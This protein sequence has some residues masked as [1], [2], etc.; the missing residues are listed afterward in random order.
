MSTTSSRVNCPSL[1]RSRIWNPSRISLTCAGGSLARAS[2]LRP[3]VA[4]I[5]AP[6]A[7]CV[8]RVGDAG[9]SRWVMDGV[10]VGEVHGPSWLV[11]VLLL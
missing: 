1:S 4:V 9:S 10:S 6:F 5:E 8:P 3:L 7:T 11:G 2:P